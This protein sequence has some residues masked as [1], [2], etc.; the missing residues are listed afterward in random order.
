MKKNKQWYKIEDYSLPE[1]ESRL[2]DVFSLYTRLRYT[3]DGGV[4]S[5]YTCPRTGVFRQDKF[6]CGH[7]ISRV[8]KTIKFSEYN[9]HV[10]C[11]DC[12]H[13]LEG[14]KPV[15]RKNL[16]KDYG[17]HI[18]DFLEAAPR[19]CKRDRFW[20]RQ[21][22]I[23]YYDKLTRLDNYHLDEGKFQKKHSKFLRLLKEAA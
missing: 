1:L 11:Y 22:I 15:Y 8:N 7:Y 18:V 17:Q 6:E 5:C 20:F 10:Q 9:N 3:T 16:I 14:N 21:M 19:Y 2:W 4:M 12:N 23:E 13:P